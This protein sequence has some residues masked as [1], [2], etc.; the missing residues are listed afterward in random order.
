MEFPSSGLV[1]ESVR[2]VCHPPGQHAV[3][4]VLRFEFSRASPLRKSQT[5]NGLVRHASEKNVLVPKFFLTFLIFRA[6]E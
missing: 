1:V 3:R 6:S 2:A 4:E 5:R